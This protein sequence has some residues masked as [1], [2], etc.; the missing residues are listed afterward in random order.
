M[1]CRHRRILE[2][3]TNV[4]IG[5]ILHSSPQTVGEHLERLFPKLDVETRT[6]AAVAPRLASEGHFLPYV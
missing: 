6:A 2:G 1:G 3:K 4:E 5:V